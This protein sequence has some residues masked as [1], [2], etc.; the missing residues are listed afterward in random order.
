[1]ASVFTREMVEAAVEQEYGETYIHWK[2]EF[3]TWLKAEANR[4][5]DEQLNAM[6]SRGEVRF[7]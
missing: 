3:Q 4:L 6:E 1:M 7:L 2:H 5:V